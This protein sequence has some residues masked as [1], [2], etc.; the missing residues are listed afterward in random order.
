MTTFPI[1]AGNFCSNVITPIRSS[2][3]FRDSQDAILEAQERY[4][5]IG[6]IG[7]CEALVDQHRSPSLNLL[8][9]ADQ[10]S[11]KIKIMHRHIQEQTATGLAGS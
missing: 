7:L 3:C 6:V 10:K 4:R 8:D 1:D 5:R 11:R 9:L 2:G